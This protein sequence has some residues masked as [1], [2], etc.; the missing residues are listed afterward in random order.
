MNL[1]ESPKLMGWLHDITGHFVS[2]HTTSAARDWRTNDPTKEASLK[3]HQQQD[4]RIH[5]AY[6]TKTNKYSRLLV[7][8]STPDAQVILLFV[9]SPAS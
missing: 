5:Q 9:K 7:W 3:K 4:T 1:V 8:R 2:I 6:P